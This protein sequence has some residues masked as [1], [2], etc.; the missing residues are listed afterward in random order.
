[1]KTFGQYLESVESLKLYRGMSKEAYAKIQETGILVPEPRNVHND[2]TS[3]IETAMYYASE[4]VHDEV[5]VVIEFYVN[6]NDV[7]EDD[8]YKGDYKILR[9]IDVS[10][11]KVVYP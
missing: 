5:G 7:K 2:A 3:D 11:H 1:M 10:N 9:P 6:K 4:K 8:L